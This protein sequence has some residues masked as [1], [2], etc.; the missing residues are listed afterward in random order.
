MKI[1]ANLIRLLAATGIL[2]ALAGG[3][4]SSLASSSSSMH[5]MKPCTHHQVMA[6]HTKHCSMHHSMKHTK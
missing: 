6:H 5:H 2:T 4:A 1:S 3:P